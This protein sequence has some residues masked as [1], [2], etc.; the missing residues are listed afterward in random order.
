MSKILAVFLFEFRSTV[1][2]RSF[3][4]STVAFPLV[5]IA[6]ILVVAILSAIDAG[7]D[8]ESTFLGYVDRWGKLPTQSQ[9]GS[10][11][12]PY[13]SEEAAR[14]ALVDE[15]IEAYFV[16]P[17]DYVETGLVQEY[18]TSE[19]SI[20]D[21]GAESAV[22]KILLVQ[23]LVEG[24]VPEAVAARLQS[25]LRIERARLTTE[26]EAA[27]EEKDEFSRFLIPYIFG[28]MLLMSIFM[29]SGLLVQAIGEEKQSRTVEILLS[30]ISAFTLITGKVLGLGAAGLLQIIIWLFTARILIFAGDSLTSLPIEDAIT[31][32]PAVMV[33]IIL[34]FLLGYLFFATLLAA[35]GAMATTPHEGQQMSAM[36]IVPGIIP[37]MLFAVIINEPDGV[38][39]RVLTFIPITAPITAMLRLSASTIP[40]GDFALSL[41]ILALS[42]AGALFISSRIFRA[43]LLLYGRRPGL[44]EVW[45]ALRTAS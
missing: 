18:S 12:I 6:I 44:R 22:L 24:Q 13:S 28:L 30:S 4:I 40:W 29:T 10:R 1:R 15:D 2:R 16:I 31:I 8:E 26:G 7:A 45:R 21:D 27:P 33:L 42:I 36:V 23:A 35:I 11:L 14:S 3:Q 17:A 41:L 25:P 37:Y 39:A 20:F 5:I 19:S 38:I 34:F 43:F 9:V 32:E